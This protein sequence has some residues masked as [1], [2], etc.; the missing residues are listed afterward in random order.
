MVT[1]LQNQLLRQELRTNMKVLVFKDIKNKR[2]TLWN[3]DK[4]KHLG[5]RKTLSLK[6]CHFFV[7]QEK[8]CKVKKSKKRF[9]HAWIIGE[10]HSR[11]KFCFREVSYNPFKNDCFMNKRRKVKKSRIAFFNSEGKVFIP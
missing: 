9:P 5:Y 3:E 4:S 7:D 10:I 11:D 8:R 2:W 6:N 1:Y